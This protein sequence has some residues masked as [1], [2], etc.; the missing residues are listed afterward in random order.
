MFEKSL[1]DVRGDYR[2]M[3]HGHDAGSYAMESGWKIANVSAGEELFNEFQSIV[4]R[5]GF[6]NDVD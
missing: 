2:Y 1:A 5:I 3:W 6:R 4:L